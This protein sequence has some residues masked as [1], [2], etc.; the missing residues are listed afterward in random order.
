MYFYLKDSNF[1][2]QKILKLNISENKNSIVENP[3]GCNFC[4]QTFLSEY[5]A[6][7]IFLKRQ[8]AL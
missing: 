6:S 7:F 5:Q 8:E 4:K 1:T 3:E 2:Q